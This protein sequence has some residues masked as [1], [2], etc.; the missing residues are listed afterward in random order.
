MHFKLIIIAIISCCSL[1]FSQ[2]LALERKSHPHFP[3]DEEH[4]LSVYQEKELIPATSL[5][6][7][8]SQEKWVREQLDRFPPVERST[9]APINKFGYL[10][11]RIPNTSG[12][13]SM[14]E[15]LSI[16]LSRTKDVSITG[17][18]LTPAFYPEHATDANYGFPKR[19]KIEGYRISDPLTPI[20]IAEWTQKDFPDPGLA[21][22]LFNVRNLAVNTVK[23]TVTAGVNDGKTTFFAL[24]EMMVF[25]DQNNIIPP[26]VNRITTSGS[27]DAPP[28]W[29][30]PYLADNLLHLGHSLDTDS[31]HSA[32]DFIHYFDKTTDTSEKKPQIIIDLGKVH[33]VGRI[34]L[35]A[36]KDTETPIPYISLPQQYRIELL[37]SLNPPRVT[38]SEWIDNDKTEKT[39]WHA[40]SSREGRY[41][42]LTFHQ[43]PI[44]NGQPV[45]ALGEIR[46]IG[47]NKSGNA[48]L[49]AGKNISFL[50]TGNNM[51]ANTSLLVDGYTNGREIIPARLH[52][53]QLAKRS[54]V[55]Q[56]YKEVTENIII[57]RAI[58]TQRYWTIGLIAGVLVLFSLLLW[59][60]HLKN[61]RKKAVLLVQQ[62]IAADLH[63]DIS[64]NLGTISMITD[65]LG[66]MTEDTNIK[67]KLRE[68]LHLSQESY[69]SI[70]E[71]I[72]HTDSEKTQLSDLFDQIKRTARSILSECNVKYEFPEGY[73]DQ[74]VPNKVRRNIILLIKESLYN[75][76]KYAK[77]ENITIHA[78]I[79]QPTLH[80]T[81]TDDGC[82]F[83]T[84]CDTTANSPSGRGLKNMERRAKLLGADL[85]INSKLGEGTQIGL[86]MPLNMK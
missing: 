53:E 28:Y 50:N 3:G 22:V 38:H 74:L 43:L 30:L 48:S 75:C 79:S 12:D 59:L 32:P 10:S 61:Q 45:L 67:A 16:K 25:R 19:F 15:W 86:I 31:D 70:K 13:V 71:I 40:L 47:S 37:K 35:Y 77:A 26:I 58:R 44:H 68:V 54:I 33:N 46:I 34:Q 39:R 56:A 73:E 65:R 29:Q 24:A 51:T 84:T 14:E 66:G 6:K 69:T 57:A 72:W 81:I 41:L 11:R 42:R 17:V 64:G 9:A 21:P 85:T 1:A 8:I 49:E 27:S 82:G 78:E 18:A 55:Q 62:Q 7:L 20:V 36:A 2:E 4:Q 60:L 76:A 23:L 52:I 63:D 5:E 83:D 80:L